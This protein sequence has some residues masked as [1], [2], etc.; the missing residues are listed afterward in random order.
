MIYQT[1]GGSPL[2]GSVRIG[3]CKNAVLPILFATLLTRGKSR[4]YGVPSITDVDT[5]LSILEAFGAEISRPEEH[6]LEID[7][8]H[9]DY[10]TPNVAS[11]RAIRASTY[12]IG[13]CLG[14]FGRAEL[15]DFGGCD[16]CKRPIDLHLMAAEAFGAKIDGNQIECKRLLA[17]HVV[18]PIVSVGATVNSLLLSSQIPELSVL[19]NVAIEPHVFSLIT[20][21]R[22][23][24]AS[25]SIATTPRPTFFV[26]GGRLR[27]V[28]MHMIP[29]MI[30]AG[31]YLLAAFISGGTVTTEGIDPS[32]LRS[33][34]ALMRDV[35][36]DL[37][38]EEHRATLSRTTPMREASIT[39][40]P[41]PG[42]P[43]DLSPILA[44]AL[45]RCGKGRLCDTV[46]PDR[47]SFL[48]PYRALGANCVEREDGTILFT[49]PD[50]VRET[51]LTVPDL[52][53][54]AGMILYA[55]SLS[56]PIEIIDDHQWILRGYED[57][58]MKINA[59]EANVSVVTRS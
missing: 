14:R 21:L 29:D 11:V 8:T 22:I 46:F 4:L 10:V 34:F 59:L 27:G 56:T 18:F 42:I 30:E 7:T 44:A 19:E 15:S 52:R 3:G 33:F 38:I 6:T 37:T 40:A 36:A 5:T 17:N 9:L 58:T 53:C 24:G 32:H 16:F 13:A 57:F 28:T 26:R 31:T 50:P 49:A 54:G 20:F 1:L 39:C 35:G 43:T 48:S 51:T 2:R 47:R 23:A 25:I 12:L 45:A 41:F 55:L